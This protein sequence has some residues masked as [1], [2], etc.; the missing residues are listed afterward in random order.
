MA[1]RSIASPKQ[2]QERA[3]PGVTGRQRNLL[4]VVMIPAFVAIAGC[5]TLVK[6][7]LPGQTTYTVR[8]VSFKGE[9][10]VD[11]SALQ[12]LLSVRADAFLIPGNPYNPYRQAE[13]ARRILVYWQTHGYLD[14]AIKDVDVTFDD[15]TSEVDVRWVVDDGAK[16]TVRDVTIVGGPPAV[17][18]AVKDHITFGSGDDVQIETYRRLRHP[19]IDQLR[20]S[21]YGHAEVYSRTYVDRTA[22]K[23]DWTYFVDEGPKTTVGSIAVAGH[24][25]VSEAAIRDR[26]GLAVGEPIDAQRIEKLEFDLMDTGA[27][28]TARLVTNAHNEFLEGQTPPDSALPPDTGGKILATQIS[29]T[30]ELVARELPSALDVT[31]VVVEAPTTSADVGLGANIDLE[32]F[33]PFARARLTW[34]NA[35]GPLHHIV[36]EGSVGYGIRWRGDVDEP[37][38]LY[39]SGLLRWVKPG[40]VGRLGDFRLT[41]AFDES[42]YPGFHWRKAFAGL[43]LRTA[44]T[45]NFHVD[46]APRFRIDWPVGVGTIG[47]ADR[48][49]LDL[50]VASRT[51]NA[52]IEAAL[53]WD[54]RD[55]RVEPL[56]GHLVALRGSYSPGGPLGETPWLRGELDLRYIANLGSGL[57]LAFRAAGGWLSDLGSD[58]G[59][60]IGARL[61]G[62]G[63]WGERAFYHRRLS[64][65]ATSCEGTTCRFVPVG[66]QSL[67]QGAVEFRW[68]P[69]RKQQGA[70][71]FVDVGAAGD[72]ANPFHDGVTVAPGLGLRVRIWHLP[73]GLDFSYRVTDIGRYEPLDRFHIFARF[74]EA[75]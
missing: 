5:S 9:P 4:G 71:A 31:A 10:P 54:A 11:V 18:A 22:K 17:Q 68:L 12:V 20:R 2:L 67:V 70:V 21:G 45:K 24:N 15:A 57:A 25:K 65:Y 50:N 37:L 46:I 16:Y 30:G 33:D 6:P 62:G 13:D 41:V 27:F 52:E 35:F 58:D 47:P 42:L 59:V 3:K 60:P 75:F 73:L 14:A 34:R 69:F 61:F 7:E 23:V 38:G 64:S 8:E 32:R 40:L 19:M 44:F 72:G 26:L 55:S 63:A 28:A 56:S 53:V 49:R 51:M 66:A 43:G 36:V 29:P 74:G 1:R 39:G 48:T